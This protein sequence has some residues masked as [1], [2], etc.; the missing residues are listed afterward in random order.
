MSTNVITLVTMVG[1]WNMCRTVNTSTGNAIIKVKMFTICNT[2]FIPTT[3]RDNKSMVPMETLFCE[4]KS[5]KHCSIACIRGS[6]CLQ[7]SGNQPSRLDQVMQCRKICNVTNTRVVEHTMPCK[8]LTNYIQSQCDCSAPL[9]R[10]LTAILIVVEVCQCQQ[11]SRTQVKNK[12]NSPDLYHLTYIS[13]NIKNCVVHKSAFRLC[14]TGITKPNKYDFVQRGNGGAIKNS[15]HNCTP[16]RRCSR[17][18]DKNYDY[19]VITLCVMGGI[20]LCL[21]Y[22]MIFCKKNPVSRDYWFF[23]TER[24]SLFGDMKYSR[25]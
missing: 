19:V 18:C 8:T 20:G 15:A 14:W 11:S 13:H 23:Y 24:K 2:S 25:W 10:N 12:R 7:I 9:S 5:N 1:L 4:N 6:V 16:E 22:R 3:S 21:Y 17:Y